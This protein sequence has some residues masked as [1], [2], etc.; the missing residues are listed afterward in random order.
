MTEAL[1]MTRGKQAW[2]TSRELTDMIRI[3]KQKALAGDVQAA[4]ALLRIQIERDEDK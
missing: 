2:P 3:I 4:E 1:K